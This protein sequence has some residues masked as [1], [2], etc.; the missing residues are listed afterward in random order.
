MQSHQRIR[1]IAYFY[2]D[3]LL[4]MIKRDSAQWTWVVRTCL[5]INLLRADALNKGSR[6]RP[7]RHPGN[8][9]VPSKT[10]RTL[11]YGGDVSRIRVLVV[12]DS[13]VVRKIVAD[14][15][16]G[17][18]EIEVIGTAADGRIA[19]KMVEQ[20]RPDLVTMDLEMPHLDG[21]E[22]VRA[23]RRRGDRLPIIIFTSAGTQDVRSRFNALA[24]GAGEFVT[25]PST[26]LGADS[27]LAQVADELIPR[28]KA[29]VPYPGPHRA[30]P[31]TGGTATPAARSD[32]LQRG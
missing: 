19:L 16:A 15:L 20:L 21:I 1:S 31:A 9:M 5:C 7:D 6:I 10:D 8:R 29:L 24:A 11:V 23:L 26:M 18:Q 25:K 2:V 30:T 22:T 3:R 4:N 32:G 28:I 12:D 13:A 14:A 27:P 17:D